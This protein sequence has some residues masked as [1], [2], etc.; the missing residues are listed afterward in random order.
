MHAKDARNALHGVALAA[1]QAG[2]VVYSTL[3]GDFQAT[4]NAGC[5]LSGP[6]NARQGQ[7]FVLCCVNATWGQK[8]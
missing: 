5:A 2:K 3:A 8:G 6:P 7:Y 1:L 4:V